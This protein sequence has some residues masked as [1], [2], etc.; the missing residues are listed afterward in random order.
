MG[1]SPSPDVGGFS[2]NSDVNGL[3]SAKIYR[4]PLKESLEKLWFHVKFP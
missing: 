3:V 2:E 4:N 1:H